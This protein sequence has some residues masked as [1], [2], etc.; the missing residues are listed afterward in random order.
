MA[1]VAMV[2][3]NQDQVKWLRRSFMEALPGFGGNRGLR[4]CFSVSLVEASW[5]VA[6]G[7]LCRSSSGGECC[8]CSFIEDRS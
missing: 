1:P 6:V 3:A 5:D 7:L 2:A 8:R 4:A